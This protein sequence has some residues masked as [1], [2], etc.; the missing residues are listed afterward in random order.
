MARPETQRGAD[1]S[2]LTTFRLPAR[3]ERLVELKHVDQLAEIDPGP[4]RLVLG[5]GSNTIFFSDWAGV[6]LINRLRGLDVERI[7]EQYSRV[8][9]AAGENWHRLVRWCLDRD[10]HG[11][12][13]LALIPGSVGAAPMQ[14]IGAYGTELAEVI[15][16]VSAWDWQTRER[17]E[18]PAAE[19]EFGY[20]SSRFKARDRDRFL[21]TAVTLRLAH[22]FRPNTRYRSLAE[23]LH[24]RYGTE[25]PQPRQ[26]AASVMRLRRH[27]LPNPTRLANAGS[28]FQNPVVS[29]E[30]AADLLD[31]HPELPHWPMPDNTCKLA[32]CWLIEQLGWK[33][34][35]IGD[36]AVHKN[37]AL[38]LVNRGRATASQLDQL[39]R[40]ISTNVE[41]TYGVRLQPEPVL[42]GRSGP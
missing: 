24:K 18:I 31:T 10:L 36:A 6:V 20:R 12:E 2:A 22:R 17:V 39:I 38:V 40:A 15:E 27:R 41:T 9:V 7:D 33:G 13:N 1:L 29:A 4:A 34:R 11:L 21:I 23:E 14:N 32:A 3:A 5:G 42:I 37:H 19:C 8:R 35:A 30:Q 26:L 25:P 16:S 28:F